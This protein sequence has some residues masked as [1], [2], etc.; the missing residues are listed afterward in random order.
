MDDYE[1]KQDSER[2]SGD[3]AKSK[4]AREPSPYDGMSVDSA[5]R[6]FSETCQGRG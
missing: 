2:P 3:S 1:R 4:F 6:H 5:K